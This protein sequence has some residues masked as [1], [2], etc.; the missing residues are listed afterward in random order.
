MFTA[1]KIDG[2]RIDIAKAIN[3]PND[4]YYCTACDGEVII[5]SGSVRIDHFA[6]KTK[7]LY[8][9]LDNDMSEWHREWQLRFPPG[10]REI[11]LKLDEMDSGAFQHKIRRTD[12]LC[13]G[14]AIEFQYSPISHDEFNK[15]NEF[16][17]KL[18]YK[19]VWIFNLI[20]EFESNKIEISGEWD[21][22]ED[23]GTTFH[24]KYASKTFNSY[25]PRNKKI[26]LLFQLFESNN[27]DP[28]ED[29]S[30]LERVTW[31]INCKSNQYDTDFKSFCT[32]YY[33]GN[34]TELLD[35]MRRRVL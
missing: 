19:V 1:K 8:D 33:P 35:K 24:W 27:I 4:K 6:H 34:F 16:Y 23:N 28:D 25:D 2:S 22:K 10:N 12:V 9:Y 11:I 3:E 32:S 18:G 29:Q 26:I 17:N 14:Y 21:Y 7:C 31:A 30:Y 15:R 5:K 13:Y 20:E